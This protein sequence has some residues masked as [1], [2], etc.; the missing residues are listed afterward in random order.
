[1]HYLVLGTPM[2]GMD[3]EGH[4]DWM[5][6]EMAAD[7]Q[8]EV[9]MMVTPEMSPDYIAAQVK[10]HNFF[11]LKPYRTFASDPANARIQDFLP[12]S[13]IEV[14]HD[15]GLAI[16]MHLAKKTGPADPEN[17]KDLQYYTKQYPRAQWDSRALRSCLQRIHDGGG[18]PHPQRDAK[19]LVRHIS[20]ERHLL[21]LFADET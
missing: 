18:N 3:A 8:S 9:N 17:I 15:M 12:E 2:P 10:K 5:A 4:N 1:M 14:A 6:A 20:G 11:G 16:T 7:P 19:Y 13:F 21:S